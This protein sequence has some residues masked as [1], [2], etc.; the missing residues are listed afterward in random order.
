[1]NFNEISSFKSR[2]KSLVKEQSSNTT[3]KGVKNTVSKEDEVVE[4]PEEL[5]S[6]D[7]HSSL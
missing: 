7:S 3:D 1:M 2:Y 5:I 4:D 6:S